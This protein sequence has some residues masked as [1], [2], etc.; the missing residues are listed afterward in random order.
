LN[1]VSGKQR[2]YVAQ[3]DSI[4]ATISNEN[5]MFDF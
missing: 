2:V 3:G 5:W 4:T 1:E